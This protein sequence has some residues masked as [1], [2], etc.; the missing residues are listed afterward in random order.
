MNHKQKVKLAHRLR[1]RQ[2]IK[3]RVSIFQTEAWSKRKA[4]IE[5]RV[6]KIGAVKK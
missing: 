4:A 5:K 3:D 2:E 1:T 6:A